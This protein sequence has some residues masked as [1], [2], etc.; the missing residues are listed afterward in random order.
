[1]GVIARYAAAYYGWELGWQ[2]RILKGRARR[3]IP[4]EGTIAHPGIDNT[5]EVLFSDIQTAEAF[6][7]NTDAALDAA[8][9]S[10]RNTSQHCGN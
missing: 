1:M 7:R 8:L 5:G 3:E 10:A 2:I 6:C 4:Q 9:E